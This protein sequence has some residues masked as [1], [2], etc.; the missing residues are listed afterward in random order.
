MTTRLYISGIA[1]V[2]LL[3]HI[4]TD[5]AR[6]EGALTAAAVRT[7]QAGIP[8]ALFGIRHTDTRRRTGEETARLFLRAHAATLHAPAETDLNTDAVQNVPGGIHVRFTQSHNG[9]RV[10]G[11]DAVVSLNRNEEVCAVVNNLREDVTD[12]ASAP[13][14]SAGEA[15]EEARHAIG[16]QGPSIG[17]PESTEL[18]LFQPPGEGW[19]RAFRVLISCEQPAGDWEVIVDALTG[20]VLAVSDLYVYHETVQGFGFAY[21]PDPLSTGRRMY[22]GT[23]LTDNN[24]ADSDSL[25]L[26]RSP[27]T[28][29][30]ITLEN[31]SYLLRGP[32]C[33]ITDIESPADPVSYTA[34]QSD[35]FAFTRSQ[36]E[37][38]AVNA[39]YHA[40]AACRHVEG[41]GFSIPRLRTLRL[42]PHGVQGEDNSRYSPTGNWISFGEGGVD[43]A[44]DA[45]VIWHEYTHAVTFGIVPTWG[46]GESGALGEGISDYVAASYSRSIAQWSPGDYHYQWIFNWDGHN[47]FWSGRVL[48]DPR[49]YPFG[50]LP[51]HTAGQIVSSAL[52]GIRDAL[53]R[54]L[55]D[56]LVFKALYYLGSGATAPD[57][58][59]ALLQADQDLHGG[60]H[61]SVL[62][63][64]LGTVK[65]FINPD[66]YLLSA[67]DGETLPTRCELGQ[68]YPNPFNPETS[69]PFTLQRP[70]EIRLEVIDAAGRSVAEL[71]T[72]RM[73]EGSHTVTWNGRNREGA[74]VSTGVYF[75]RLRVN[76]PDGQ[77]NLIRRMILLR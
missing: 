24:D 77:E 68:N 45:D 55:T 3:V 31:G 29:D 8:R 20:S 25:T 36:Q 42:D 26:L 4:P 6:S 1:A 53:G 67:G 48:N 69:I 33:S 39:Y 19:H 60:S 44:E 32:Y 23:G 22:G 56:Q 46:G 71:R 74:D 62:V 50:P 64:W 38:E 40:V 57:F 73:Q 17:K 59:R 76:A 5:S 9:I 35:G 14:I 75:Y 10:Y 28:L 63:F 58:A 43:D 49:T 27:V 18:V 37:F 2:L 70:A 65:K 11:A 15:L 41:L 12:G 7:D 52:M 47:P 13:S 16:T 72:G 21:L 66:E 30:S 54:D 34:P 61:R 51:I